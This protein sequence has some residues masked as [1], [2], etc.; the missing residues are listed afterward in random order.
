MVGHIVQPNVAMSKNPN[1]SFE[2]CLPTTL[3]KEMLQGVLR[4][5]F[6]FNGVIT[7]D[8]TIMN[9]YCQSMARKDALPLSL[10]AGCDM[11]VFNT[12]FQ[13][14]Y[15]YILDALEDERVTQER[16]EEAVTRILALKIKMSSDHFDEIPKVEAA[17]W[18]KE[19]ADKCITLVKDRQN[20]FPVTPEKFPRIRL[21]S[22]GKD[23]VVSGVAGDNKGEK[24]SIKECAKEYL[25]SAGF[26]VELYDPFKDNLHGTSDLPDDRLI[27]WLSN[28]E[29]ASNQTT[30]RI[31]WCRKHALDAPRFVNEEPGIFVSFGNPYLLMDVPR[32][33]TYINAYTATS[34][35]IEA[36]LNKITGKGVFEGIS[37]VDAFCGLPDTRL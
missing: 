14:D 30:V 28:Y 8:A 24:I 9:G 25:E 19:C 7:T 27:L 16:L 23:E 3:S 12:D 13:E 29:Q 4:E 26:E 37:P 21:I 34:P 36:T 20:I 15:Q 17:K 2:D 35:I 18:Q 11:F 32:V 6:G 1:L 22:L 31:E 5:E 33:K 10:M